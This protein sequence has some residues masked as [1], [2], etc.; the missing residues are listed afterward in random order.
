MAKKTK[1][2]YWLFTIITN[3]NK[4]V[5]CYFDDFPT[6][7]ALMGVCRDNNA[8][9]YTIINITKLTEEQYDKLTKY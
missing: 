4:Y 3:Y 5:N 2:E 8:W 6:R 7:D 9:S 1:K